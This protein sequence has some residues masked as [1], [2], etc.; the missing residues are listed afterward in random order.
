MTGVYEQLMTSRGWEI[1]P[2]QAELVRLLRDAAA[3]TPTPTTIHAAALAATLAGEPLPLLTEPTPDQRVVV[4]AGTGVGKTL[5][6]LAVGAELGTP[7]RP[8]VVLIQTNGLARQYVG[9]D[10]DAITEVAGT[11]ICRV[12]GARYYVC[13]SS[14]AGYDAGLPQD[15]DEVP[16]TEEAYRER[17]AWLAEA[18]D[19]NTWAT[20]WERRPH[21]DSDTYACPGWP[22]CRGGILGGCGKRHARERGRIAAHIVVTNY[23]LAA[24][25]ATHSR[26]ELLP[27]NRAITIVEEAHNLPDIICDILSAS[28]GPR[29]GRN[30][31]GID[32]RMTDDERTATNRLR[33]WIAKLR[34]SRV[35]AAA[36]PDDQ[37]TTE[38]RA[39]LLGTAQIPAITEAINTWAEARA[40]LFAEELDNDDAE[41]DEDDELSVAAVLA[42][43]LGSAT[44]RTIVPT[45]YRPPADPDIN[46]PDD[47]RPD[48]IYLHRADAGAFIAGRLLPA[49][50]ALVSGTIPVNLPARCGLDSPITDV[51][52]P[53]DYRVQTRG[54]I[55]RHDGRK[56]VGRGVTRAQRDAIIGHR[57]DEL[58][59]FVRGEPALILCPSHADV[60]LVA[61]GLD[62]RLG[63]DSV[64]FT[65]PRYGGS[66]AAMGIVAEFRDRPGPRVLIGTDSY[67][68]GLDLPG[69]LLTR[70]AWWTLPIGGTS[71]VDQ[72]R[73]TMYPGRPGAAPV[74]A[75]GSAHGSYLDDRLRVK[76]VQGVGR[77]IRT[78]S[79]RGEILLCDARFRDHLKGATTVLDAHLRTIPWDWANRRTEKM[80]EAH[81]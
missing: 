20:Q 57:L 25:Q 81:A 75:G 39:H 10:A 19:A 7:G 24:V 17:E 51:G 44:D 4:Q 65:Q 72:Q 18:T 53:F 23:H 28:L 43:V 1:R 70:V 15:P 56:S 67:A 26:L 30:S 52:H 45:L 61:R 41:P 49:P 40:R 38:Q 32:E 59:E 16:D 12:I 79:D 47:R 73:Q 55:S 66:E 63:F 46:P 36:W 62:A 31:F 35:E 48:T 42:L 69:E 9:R 6:V 80:M 27:A 78:T 58:A 77:L 50:A 68:T 21:Q 11:R 8:A 60:R 71:T 5:G 29:F 74:P 54:W 76:V 33:N 13:A 3:A 14:P 64:L 37:W 34:A 2:Q 22:Q